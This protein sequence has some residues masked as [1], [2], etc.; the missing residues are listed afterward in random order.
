MFV[1]SFEIGSVLYKR[2]A[3]RVSG[4]FECFR[5]KNKLDYAPWLGRG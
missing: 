4:L 3:K 2:K 5:D 1:F